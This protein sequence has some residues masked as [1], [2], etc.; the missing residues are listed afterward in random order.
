MPA[1][2]VVRLEDRPEQTYP[3]H[4]DLRVR[5]ALG[6]S[7]GVEAGVSMY[8][9]R[10]APGQGVAVTQHDVDETVYLAAGSARLPD[11]TVLGAGTCVF[12]PA[13]T[14]HGLTNPGPGTLELVL[15][16]HARR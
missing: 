2:T 10:V 12:L 6:P 7:V 9:A 1:P 14:P 16:I 5:E 15:L 11:G 13:G 3:L 4:S 8:V